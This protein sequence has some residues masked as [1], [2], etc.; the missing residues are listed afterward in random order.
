M[1]AVSKRTL[2]AWS[3]QQKHKKQI[4]ATPSHTPSSTVWMLPQ[5]TILLSFCIHQQC[6]LRLAVLLHK[7]PQTALPNMVYSYRKVTLTITQRSLFFIRTA[8]S[9]AHLCAKFF[10][11]YHRNKT[12]VLSNS[13][14]PCAVVFQNIN[15]EVRCKFEALVEA[16][17]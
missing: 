10:I 14:P 11:G 13:I 2:G 3:Q 6:P 15:S 1:S 8:G 12:P 4:P 7:L 16:E 17:L 9:S 5:V